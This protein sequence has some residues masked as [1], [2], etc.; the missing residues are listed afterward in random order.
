MHIDAINMDLGHTVER[1]FSIGESDP[2]SAR[3]EITERLMMR[4]GKWLIRVRV[5]TEL[6]ADASQFRLRARLSAR[7]GDEEVFAR[8]WDESVPRDCL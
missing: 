7:E 2:L 3:A 5:N 6:T 8:E 1:K 4:R